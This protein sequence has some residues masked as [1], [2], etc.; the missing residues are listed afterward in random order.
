MSPAASQGVAHYSGKYESLSIDKFDPCEEWNYQ[1][2]PQLEE[3][4]MAKCKRRESCEQ[5][6]GEFT[7]VKGHSNILLNECADVLATMGRKAGRRGYEFTDAEI[8]QKKDLE[9]PPATAFTAT[10]LDLTLK[11]H[12][13]I[14]RGIAVREEMERW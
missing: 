4:W 13:A 12:A 14:Q 7:W 11:E 8:A 3:E 10:S 2:D 6:S 5:A 1:V 9:E